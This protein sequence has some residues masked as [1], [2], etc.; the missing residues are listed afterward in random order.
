M[1]KLHLQHCVVDL[2]RAKVHLANDTKALTTKEVALLR[3]LA[4]RPSEIV[5]REDLLA[6]LA[7]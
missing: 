3:Y 6:L 7:D 4:E 1:D 5:T 2:S